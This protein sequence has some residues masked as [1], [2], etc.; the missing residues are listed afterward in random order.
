MRTP[1]ALS[2]ALCATWLGCVAEAQSTLPVLPAVQE[3]TEL[4]LG[5]ILKEKNLAGYVPVDGGNTQLY[6]WLAESRNDPTS[7]PLIVWLNG[8]PGISSMVG[9]LMEVGPYRAHED[10]GVVRLIDNDEAWNHKASLLVIDQPGGVGY[11][12][13][14]SGNTW[15]GA[16]TDPHQATEMLYDALQSFLTSFPQ[17]R[18][19]DVYLFGE[20]YAGHYV[21]DLATRIHKGMKA[22]DAAIKLEGIG[23]CD[24]WVAPDVQYAAQIEHAWALGLLTNDQREDLHDKFKEEIKNGTANPTPAVAATLS[25]IEVDIMEASGTENPF[26]LRFE[27]PLD[28]KYIDKWLDR[29]DVRAAIHADPEDYP[30]WNLLNAAVQ[31]GFMK[32]EVE[33]VAHHFPELLKKIRILSFNGLEDLDCSFLGED[34]WL[35]AIDWEH[36]HKF[37]KAQRGPWVEDGLVVG[38]I[39]AVDNLTQVLV[40]DAGHMVP[41]DQPVLARKIVERF[42]AG[43]PIDRRK[44]K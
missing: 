29:P 44:K 7:D 13:T 31:L 25:K 34:R 18:G 21:P 15:T 16:V 39:R 23:L 42:L 2:L 4:P 41:R 26:H 38:R 14:A 32:A 20:S 27:K 6:V 12:R 17:Y 5:P 19:L 24:A 22:G 40:V 37:N 28:L 11:S 30:A 36:Q 33:S 10:Q 43:E 8:G 35:E 9:M 3:V 1:L